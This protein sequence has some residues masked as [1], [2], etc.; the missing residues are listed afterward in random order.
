[1]PMFRRAAAFEGV[2]LET[3]RSIERVLLS[4]GNLDPTEIDRLAHVLATA[5]PSK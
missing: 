3:D 2:R 1:M 5:L 4:E